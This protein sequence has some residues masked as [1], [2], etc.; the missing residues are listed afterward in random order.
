MFA[1]LRSVPKNYDWGTP[2]AMSELQGLAPTAQPEAELWFGSHPMARCT[3][4]DG[5]KNPDFQSWLDTTGHEFPLLVKFLAAAKP[6][7]I[8]VHPDKDQATEGFARENAKGL[9]LDDPHRMFK[10][11]HPKPELLI[12][13]SDTFDALWGLLPATLRAQR[14][15]RFAAT[16]LASRTVQGLGQLNDQDAVRTALTGGDSVNEWAE[17]LAAW[18]ALENS[19]DSAEGLLERDIFRRIA[20]EF[21]G[22]RGI[23]LAFLMHVLR[24]QRGEALFVSPGQIHAYVGGFGLEVML[25]SDNVVRGGLTSKHQDADLFLQTATA[26]P[27]EAPPRVSPIHRDGRSVYES[28]TMPFSIS[29]IT[30]GG[31]I[32]TSADA[33]ILGENGTFALSRAGASQE[34]Q[35]GEV[36]FVAGASDPLQ[37]S[38]QGAAWLVEPRVD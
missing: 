29:G 32:P 36:Y 28:P 5:G 12:A 37:V 1:R 25:P 2:N 14:L 7:S 16:G 19:A 13:L 35:R 26:P 17:D 31:E 27:M 8:Q 24:L 4:E 3:V 11:P 34:L 18:S 9:A 6:L 20:A 15:E 38:G 33:L 22:D 21:P 10:D 23:V 30:A